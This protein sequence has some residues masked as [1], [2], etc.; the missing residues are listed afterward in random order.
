[1]TN[2]L[3]LSRHSY[4]GIDILVGLY[5]STCFDIKYL[6]VD[7]PNRFDK[8]VRKR[9]TEFAV[10]RFLS[11][12]LLE[13]YGVKTRAIDVGAGGE[14]IWPDNFIGSIS[15]SEGVT[16]C[17]VLRLSR[18]QYIGIDVE[19]A[20]NRKEYLVIANEVLRVE[21][22]KIYEQC[23]KPNEIITTIIFSAKEA[24]FKAIY[25]DINQN[26]T[27]SMF[28][29]IAWNEINQTLVLKLTCHLATSFPKGRRFECKYA[30]KVIKNKS[31]VLTAVAVPFII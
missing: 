4:L 26:L 11:M 3:V 27:F 13:G 21:E 15:H 2:S 8:V 17:S 25:R 16:I 5:N 7:I 10:G 24:L 12:L 9:K 28:E 18:F 22:F 19:L 1:M 14:P 29:V 30:T 6:D 23:S 31:F 20:L